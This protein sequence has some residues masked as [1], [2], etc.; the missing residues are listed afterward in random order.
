MQPT[1]DQKIQGFFPPQ[2]MSQIQHV[3]NKLSVLPAQIIS[4]TKLSFWR[5][6]Q[7]VPSKKPKTCPWYLCLQ[8]LPDPVKHPD[9]T[10]EY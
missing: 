8:Y 2:H 1:S 6:D 7:T 4:Y 5:L 9:F 10:R 3:Q